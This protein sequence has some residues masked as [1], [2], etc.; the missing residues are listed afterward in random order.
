MTGLRAKGA[1]LAVAFG[2]LTF[3]PAYPQPP[4]QPSSQARFPAG[5]GR[6]ALFKVCGSCHGPESVLGQ[7][8]THDEW[9]KTLDEMAANGAEGS[10][11][12]WTQIQAYLDKHYSLIFINKAAAKDLEAPLDVAASV[13]EAIVRQRTQTGP[14]KSIDDLKQVP[15]VTASAIEVRKDR[16]IF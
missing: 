1:G 4:A 14:Y 2:S 10:D 12:E 3:A 13:A 5:P 11:E 16:L 15:G 7:L 9:R 8:K 6:D